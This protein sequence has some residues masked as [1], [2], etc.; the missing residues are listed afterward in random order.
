MSELNEPTA[1]ESD[2]DTL[3]PEHKKLMAISDKSQEIGQFLEWMSEEK[4]Y[5]FGFLGDRDSGE[6][7]DRIY[8]TY[9]NIQEILAEYFE[10]DRDAIEREKRA[11]LE[12]IRGGN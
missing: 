6:N 3:Y 8:P 4:H 5:Q 7:P 9:L 12:G 10:I 11:M 2:L 1:V